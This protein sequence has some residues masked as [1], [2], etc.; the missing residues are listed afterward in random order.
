MGT[1]QAMFGEWDK[2]SL[3]AVLAE[4][5]GDV[6]SAVDTVLAAGSPS[7]WAV[8][9]T[10]EPPLP[11]PPSTGV[12]ASE[13]VLPAAAAPQTTNA[14]SVVVP[15]GAGPGSQLRLNHA[16]R[17]FVVTIP[18]GV[19]SGG[20][21]LATLPAGQ[22]D[23]G[24]MTHLSAENTSPSST[25]VITREGEKR[26]GRHV[27]LP[28]DFL[29]LP[30]QLSDEQLAMALQ[31]EDYLAAD[32]AAA[33]QARRREQQR[34]AR[35]SSTENQRSQQTHGGTNSSATSMFAS[36]G[37]SFRAGFTSAAKNFQAVKTKLTSK[38][39]GTE[40]QPQAEYGRLDLSEELQEDENPLHVAGSTPAPAPSSS[41]TANDDL[42]VDGQH[43]A[44]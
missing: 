40:E 44:L 3:A 25:D 4:S 31:H 10:V 16:G 23:G 30:Q 26:R 22:H 24:E 5:N 12:G 38:A 21:F 17:S 42:G 34:A 15:Q 37:D 2:E 43:I 1:L 13:V 32:R 8:Q 33:L 27:E 6:E 7:A 29:C 18:A 19:Q 11:A 28:D 41:N 35:A 36:V 20:R 14:I 39:Q 9:R